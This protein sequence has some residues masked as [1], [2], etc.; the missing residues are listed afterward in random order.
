[1]KDRFGRE[2]HLLRISVTDRCNFQCEYCVSG[3]PSAGR[4]VPGEALLSDDETVRIATVFASLGFDSWRVTGGEPLVRPGVGRLI[5]RLRA[6]PGNRRTGITTNGFF[7]TRHLDELVRAD[8]TSV[9][10]SLD[11]LDP[12]RFEAICKGPFAPVW[13]GVQALLRSPIRAKKLNCVMAAGLTDAEIDDLVELT[14]RHD[15]AVR[16]I[17]VMPYGRWD[18]SREKG[19]AARDVVERLR[20]TVGLLPNDATVDGAGPAEYWRVP[21][22]PG[23]VG[24][25]HPV[26]DKFCAACNRVRLTADGRLKGCLLTE[27]FVPIR[28]LLRSGTSDDDLRTRISN[29]VWNKAEKHA[30]L[31]AFDMKLIGG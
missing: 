6:I 12:R 22:A 26:S 9:N 23:V 27:D 30:D 17:E 20:R 18:G 10:V 7:L 21:G 29:A 31:R 5:A 25:I 1:V 13:E 15:V 8:V 4:M 11:T 14:V 2:I 28:E 16:F 19:P 24:F 3:D